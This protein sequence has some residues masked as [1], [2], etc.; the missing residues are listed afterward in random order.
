MHTCVFICVYTNRAQYLGEKKL[1]W[2]MLAAA[3]LLPRNG[4]RRPHMS[5]EIANQNNRGSSRAKHQAVQCGSLSRSPGI[6]WKMW[7]SVLTLDALE[8]LRSLSCPMV[9]VLWR[10]AWLHLQTWVQ[11]AAMLPCHEEHSCPWDHTQDRHF[12][13]Q[14]ASGN[15]SNRKATSAVVFLMT[16]ENSPK[17]RT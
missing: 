15:P 10:K 4:K 11:S 3:S 12:H 16:L 7:P 5:Q 1:K 14:A 8:T 17:E 9:P 2:M 13:L 6:A